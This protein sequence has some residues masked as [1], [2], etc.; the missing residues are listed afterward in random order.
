MQQLIDELKNP[1]YQGLSDQQAADLI[2]ALTVKIR[3]PVELWRIEQHASQK[4]YRAKLEIASRDPLSMCREVAINILRYI[5]SRRLETVDMD[6]PETRQMLGAMTQCGFA[7]QDHV[8]ELIAMGNH[9]IRWVDYEGIGSVCDG[10]VHNARGV[11]IN[12]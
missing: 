3:K 7:L 10:T 5:E 6:L 1:A 9:T 2:N 4:G 11:I 12:A 8:D